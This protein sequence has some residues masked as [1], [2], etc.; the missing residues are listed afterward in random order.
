MN[1]T[2][3]IGAPFSGWLLCAAL[4]ANLAGC[5]I[6]AADAATDEDERIYELDYRVTIDPG[7]GGARVEL[8]L[9]Q[10]DDF[11]RELDM[12]RNDGSISDVQGDGEVSTS[13]DRVVWLPPEDGGTL[14]WFVRISHRRG[15]DSYDA[16]IDDDWALFR[17]ED[18][19]PSANTRT[20][21]G[22]ESETRLTFELP[23]GWS[24]VTPY[25]GNND[26]F[27]IEE[28]GRRFD[29]PQ[30]WIVLGDLGIRNDEIGDIRTKVAA[31]VGQDV[32]RMD[33]L[34]LLRWNL[35]ELLRLL[36]DFPERLTIVS[37]GAPMWRGALSAPQSIYI[38]A[39]RPLISENGTSTLLHETV[40][41]G[42]GISAERGAD[43]IVEGLAEYYALE[44]LRRSGTIS[45]DRF[46]SARDELAEWGRDVKDLC[47]RSST[48]KVTARA[49]T[50]LTELNGEIMKASDRKASLDN[51]LR[52]TV[53]LGEKIT[54]ERFRDI[55]TRIA[56]EPMDALDDDNLPGCD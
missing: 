18:I 36:P 26:S 10:P 27:A 34:A 52:E 56:G 53:S 8:E 14:R 22:A 6:P 17:A 30:G 29:T 12:P 16:Y 50:I 35:P 1:R 31:P 32:R 44:I 43:W 24:S 40:H 15:D 46:R 33:I 39:D 20:L 9:D 37:A 28:P 3:R 21:R 49:V 45:N 38:H 48:G 7:A 19:I 5:R 2:G 54:V 11:L 13:E 55:V 4:A 47:R 25:F 41:V 23:K 42:A 51:V